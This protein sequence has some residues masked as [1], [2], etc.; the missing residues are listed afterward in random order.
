MQMRCVYTHVVVERKG[1]R[2]VQKPQS[3]K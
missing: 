1:R 2:R 3:L